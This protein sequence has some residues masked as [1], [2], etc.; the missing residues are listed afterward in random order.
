[1]SNATDR[2]KSYLRDLQ[3]KI[4]GYVDGMGGIE[5]YCADSEAYARQ[6]GLGGL[7]R[8]EWRARVNDLKAAHGVPADAGRKEWPDEFRA[9]HRQLQ[10]EM[11]EAAAIAPRLELQAALAADVDGLSAADASR[12]ID[13]L[14]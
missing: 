4:Q 11:V 3:S 1:M 13:I 2:Q 14:K 10:V 6:R 12:Y 8:E 7:D 5:N 9:A